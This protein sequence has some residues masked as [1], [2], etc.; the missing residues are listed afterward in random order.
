MKSYQRVFLFLL[1]VLFLTALLSPWMAKLWHVILEY[2]PQWEPYR[3][4][5]SRVFDRLFMVLGIVLFFFF[6]RFLKLQSTKDLGLQPT[7]YAGRDLRTGFLIGV[8]SVAALVVAMSL[9]EIFTPYFR[10]P[11][12]VAIER[13]VKAILAAATASV[14][15]EIFFRAII[16]KGLAE[17][18]NPTAR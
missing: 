7:G 14:L 9:A 4:P 3:I 15:E 8:G 6:R 16:F 5:F 11:L 1:V 2:R 18:W 17:D 12:S 10:L 13:T